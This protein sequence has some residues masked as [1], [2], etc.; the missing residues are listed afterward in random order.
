VQVYDA[1]EVSIV[2]RIG[3]LRRP[4]ARERRVTFLEQQVEVCGDKAGDASSRGGEFQ[5]NPVG[6]ECVAF[7]RTD[8]FGDSGTNI[9]NL[10]FSL[11]KAEHPIRRE[12][13]PNAS[14]S[15]HLQG[16]FEQFSRGAT[17]RSTEN[18]YDIAAKLLKIRKVS[19]GLRDSCP[20]KEDD[21]ALIAGDQK[22][23]RDIWA[24]RYKAHVGN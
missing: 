15:S 20:A 14:H 13:A 3:Q 9:R 24:I 2:S 17:L 10:E 12:Q 19:V 8:C 16:F 23:L 21:V 18:V 7:R 5:Q 1:A 11:K 22:F 6:I 4:G